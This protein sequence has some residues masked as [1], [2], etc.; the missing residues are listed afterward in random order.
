VYGKDLR[1][2][3]RFMKIMFKLLAIDNWT[4][5]NGPFDRFFSNLTRFKRRNAR[6]SFL[7]TDFRKVEFTSIGKFNV[8][9]FDGPHDAKD[10]RDGVILAQ[11]ALDDQF[12]MIVDDWNWR[13]SARALS[14]VSGKQTSSSTMSSRSAPLLMAR[15]P[16]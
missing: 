9:L 1:F 4:E 7:E 12:I 8:S 3:L 16:S 13:P 5:F 14:W 15:S 2:A 6:V 11:P 10:Q